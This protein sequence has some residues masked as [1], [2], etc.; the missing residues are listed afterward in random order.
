MVVVLG[1]VLLDCFPEYKRIGGA[2]FNVAFHLWHLGSAVRFLSRIGDDEDGKYLLSFL[3]RRGFPTVDL[4]IDR[5]RPTGRVEVRFD[6][7]GDPSFNIVP[8]AAYDALEPSPDIAEALGGQARLLYFGTLI[9]RTAPGRAAL[10]GLLSCRNPKMRCLV[11]MNLRPGC[12]SRETVLFSLSVADILKLNHD[13]LEEVITIC[14]LDGKTVDNVVDLMTV[15]GIET[16]ALTMGAGGSRIYAGEGVVEAK[17]GLVQDFQN[18]VGA[19]DG[20]AAILAL[21]HLN[22][23][24]PERILNHATAFASRI[25]AIDGAVPESD[26]FY[27]DFMQGVLDADGS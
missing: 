14:R 1:E 18:S 19:G 7:R 27:Q 15:F 12:Y 22:G 26:A 8:D 25:C 23:W 13:E 20:F 4:Q 24:P 21:G 11:D 9:Q 3:E 10:G 5:M 16:V 17:P 2:P 6:D